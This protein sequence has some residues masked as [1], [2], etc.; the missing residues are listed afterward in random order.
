MKKLLTFIFIIASTF[1]LYSQLQNKDYLKY[2]YLSHDYKYLDD[3]FRVNISNDLFQELIK[4]YNYFPERIKTCR[5]SLGVVLMGEF[6]DWHKARVAKYR[7][8]FNYLRASYYLWTTE[9]EIKQMCDKYSYKYVYDFY[10]Y[11]SSEEDDWDDDMKLFMSELRKKVIEHTG[12]KSVSEMTN[13][14]FLKY[15]LLCNPQRIKDYERLKEKRSNGEASCGKE[16]CCQKKK[17]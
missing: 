11:F 14:E 8:L 13:K 17:E 1:T 6:D 5:D 4:K 15:T 2:D 7:I 16:D 3:D 9:Y 12:N 10:E